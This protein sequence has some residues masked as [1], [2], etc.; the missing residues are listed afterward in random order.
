MAVTKLAFSYFTNYKSRTALTTAAVALSVSLVV[1]VTSGYASAE[2]VAYRLLAVYMG[3]ADVQITR[4]GEKGGIPDTVLAELRQEPGVLSAVGRLQVQTGLIGSDG[5]PFSGGPVRVVGVERPGDVAIEILN[6]VEGNWFDRSD[7][8]IAVIDQVLSDALGIGVGGR[9]S[10]GSLEGTLQLEVVGIT[11]KPAVIAPHVQSVY[12]PLHTLQRFVFHDRPPGLSR[13]MI[14]LDPDEP[15]ATFVSRW[16]DRLAQ[17]DPEI[18]IRGA[19]EARQELENNLL[20][21]RTMSYLGGTVS[22][23]AATFIVFATLSMGVSERSRTLAMLRAVGALRG[24]VAGVVLVEGLLLGSAGVAVGV[25]LGLGFVAALVRQ[26]DAFFTA[27]MV[28]SA[29]GVALAAA[30]TLLAAVAASLLPAWKAARVDPVEA[31]AV[32]AAPPMAGPPILAS[33]AGLAL[34]AVDPLLMFGPWK[35]AL[36]ALGVDDPAAA[37]RAGQFFGHFVLG[38]PSL[39]IGFFLLS[40]LFVWT[41]ERVLGPL[42]APVSAIPFALLKHQLSGGIWRA[43]GTCAALMVGLSIL[44]VMQT[45]GNTLISGWV[46]PDRFPD[47]LIVSGAGGLNDEQVAKLDAAPGVRAGEVAPLVITAPGLGSGFFSIAGAVM[48]PDTTMFIGIDPDTALKMIDLDFRAGD[49][50]TARRLLKQG[51]H[52]LV[53]EEFRRLKGLTVGDALPLKDAQGRWVEYTVAGVVW[54]PGL[55]VLAGRVDMDRQMERQ[56]AASLFGTIEDARRDFRAGDPWLFLANLEIGVP[57]QEAVE[58]LQEHL[59]VKGL[60]VHDIRQVKY[61]MQSALQQLLTVLSTVAFAALA[62]ASLGVTNAIHASVRSRRWQFGILRSVG[63]TRGQLLRLVLAEALL[64]GLAAS[65]MGIVAGLEMSINARQLSSIIIG[66][67]PP[68]AVP[69]Q[70]VW[71]GAGAVLAVALAAGIWPALRTARAE[72]LSLLQAGRSAT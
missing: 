63:V 51:R 37:A 16:S 8:N 10:L 34:I 42:V 39:M 13:I 32:L 9:F 71:I 25:P 11:R 31:M 18:E 72:P 27:G 44:V 49:A 65:A 60:A 3:T 41:V 59:G 17:V 56:T 26:F 69:W 43:A 61:Q 33:F 47:V 14:D 38:L 30:G 20:G 40:P 36:G 54:S 28:V 35:T 29:G 66:Y 46:L 1:A 67:A 2:A 7:G 58:N 64:L 45:Q 19:G 4:P 48:I 57:K 50:E 23:L 52:V 24:Q 22:M 53:T 55:D 21:M 70:V 62:V 15:T 68:L 5:K 12:L 6:L